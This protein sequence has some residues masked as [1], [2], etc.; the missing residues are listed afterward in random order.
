MVFR[1]NCSRELWEGPLPRT[2]LSCKGLFRSLSHKDGDQED[3]LSKAMCS[4]SRAPCTGHQLGKGQGPSEC[5]LGG[6][7]PQTGEL[8]T[9]GK[10]LDLKEQEM[11][12]KA[13]L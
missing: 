4:V 9:K 1:N 7:Q 13:M 5:G 8:C 11:S 2:V 3:G 12:M 6:N 10:A